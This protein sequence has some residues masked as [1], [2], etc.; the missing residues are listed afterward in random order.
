M[1]QVNYQAM[2]TEELKQY[3]LQ[4]REDKVALQVYLDKLN[5]QPHDVIT[6]VDDPEFDAKIQAAILQKMA[7]GK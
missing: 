6:T 3:W 1:S 2:S 5:E 7:G 4:H